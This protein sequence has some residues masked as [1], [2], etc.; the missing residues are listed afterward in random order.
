MSAMGSVIVMMRPRSGGS[1]ECWSFLLLSHDGSRRPVAK[2]GLP[3]RFRDAWQFACMRHLAQ[4]D[5]AQAELLIH[6]VRPA[7]A[8][9]TR[10]TA[11]LELRLAGRLLDKSSLSHAQFFLNGE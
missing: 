2:S 11:H 6:R 8:L 7:A 5:P 10:V 4:A 3:R 1:G 9:A